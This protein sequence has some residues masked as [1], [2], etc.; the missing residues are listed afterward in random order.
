MTVIKTPRQPSRLTMLQVAL[1][2]FREKGH[3]ATTVDEICNRAGVTKGSFFHHFKNKQDLV[4][5]AVD[6][7]N[8]FT[9]ELF[10]HAAYHHQADPLDRLLGYVDLRIA[11]VKGEVP[12]FTCLLG[13]L[14]QETYHTHPEVRSAC[15]AGLSAHIAKL[16]TD[17]EAAKALYAADASWS[18]D[19][20]G[21]FIQ[22]VLQG[23]FIFAKARQQSN[24]VLESLQHLRCY[25][26]LLFNRPQKFEEIKS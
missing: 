2:V 14:V 17:V 16:S 5:S 24:V 21:D 20:V 15:D 11:I 7:W 18:A 13:T 19:S 12:E 6:Y 25:L 8:E 9:G 22:V 10:A 3:A 1:Q 23:A 4:L 26:S